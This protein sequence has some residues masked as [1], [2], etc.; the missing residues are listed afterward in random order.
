MFVSHQQPQES[1]G[2]LGVIRKAT[3]GHTLQ[4]HTTATTTTNNNKRQD[5]T[6]GNDFNDFTSKWF[7]DV[8]VIGSMVELKR[9]NSYEL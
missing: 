7:E 6:H 9:I 5:P 8:S 4:Q 3:R 2:Q 1:H